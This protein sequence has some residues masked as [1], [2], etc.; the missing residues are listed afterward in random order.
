[1]SSQSEMRQVLLALGIDVETASWQSLAACRTIDLNLIT[2]ENDIFYDSYEKSPGQAKQTDQ[3]CVNCPVTKECFFF[4]QD[5]ELTGVF[6]GFY[7]EK[8]IVKKERNK[9]KT[10]EVVRELSRK[11]FDDE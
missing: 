7:L 11:I 5:N 6:G 1:M 4:G 2:A 8:G 10:Q 9:H 3:T